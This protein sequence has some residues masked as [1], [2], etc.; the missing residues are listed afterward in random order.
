MAITI[1]GVAVKVN[2]QLYSRRLGGVGKITVSNATTARFEITKGEYTRGFTVTQGGFIA[3]ERD[4]YWH[5]PLELD[6]T[7]SQLALR[8]KIQTI[9]DALVAGF[10]A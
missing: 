4:L 2:D 8:P 9:V 10:G 1:N 3:G 7:P 6:L 5:E